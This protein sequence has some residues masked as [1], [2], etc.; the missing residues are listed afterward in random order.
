MPNYLISI[1][2]DG[3]SKGRS[4]ASSVV[5][6]VPSATSV[7]LRTLRTLRALRWMVSPLKSVRCIYLYIDL[8][9]DVAVK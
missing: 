1:I 4:L 2:N 5:A 6:S 8:G 9:F 3:V 7:A